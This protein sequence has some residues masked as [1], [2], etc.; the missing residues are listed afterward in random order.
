MASYDSAIP[1]GGVGKITL[2][3]KTT[4]FHGKIT[5]SA[6]VIS[7]DPKQ[8][9]AKI[10]LSI[11]VRQ[12]I[13]VEPAAR[14]FLAGIEGDDVRGVFNLRAANDQP[15]E[16]I[17]VETNPGLAIDY[18]LNRKKD[19]RQYELEVKAK[20]TDKQITSGF[21][22][23]FTNHPVKKELK[24]PVL[25]RIN[26]ELEARPAKIYFSKRSQA[27]TK[28]DKLRRRLTLVNNRGKPFQ[29]RELSYNKEYFEV[30]P[31][32][33]IDQPASNHQFEVFA[34][35]ERLPASRVVLEDTL[36][37]KIDGA[38]TTELQVPISIRIKTAQ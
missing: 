23:I 31:I 33:S 19:G 11:N 38:Q 12:H 30:R 2:E 7:N 15:L 3:V 35:I 25:I 18:N 20:S 6:R 36:T 37:I 17:K 22:N 4:G 28:V 21:L 16:I 27:G 10:S 32:R 29:V 13:I 1:P 26:P 9:N 5:K 14:I 34:F 8:P 24:L